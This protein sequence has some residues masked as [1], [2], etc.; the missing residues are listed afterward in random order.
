MLKSHLFLTCS[1]LDLK[2]EKHCCEVFRWFALRLR[3]NN[4]CDKKNYDLILSSLLGET[5]G[6]FL[7]LLQQTSENNSEQSLEFAYFYNNLHDF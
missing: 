7:V 1:F 2:V 4:I 6:F 5:I 3:K